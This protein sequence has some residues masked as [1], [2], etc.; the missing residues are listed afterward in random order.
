[1]YCRLFKAESI[2]INT[3]QCYYRYALRFIFAHY[4]NHSLFLLL[5]HFK[6]YET[7]VRYERFFTV[8]AQYVLRVLVS[9]S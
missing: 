5:V 3:Q 7:L 4:T 8:E 9:L 2:V 1:M 6:Y